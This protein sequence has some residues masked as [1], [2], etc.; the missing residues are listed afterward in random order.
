VQK[1]K[2]RAGGI[3]RVWGNLE[4]TEGELVGEVHS[5]VKTDV[6]PSQAG[7]GGL[8]TF[9]KKSCGSTSNSFLIATTNVGGKGVRDWPWSGNGKKLRNWFSA[10]KNAETW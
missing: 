5:V 4:K 6:S 2:D 9:H 1:K 10:S 3:K 8:L 7:K